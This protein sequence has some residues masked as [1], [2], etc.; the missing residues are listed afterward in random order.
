MSADLLAFKIREAGLPEPERE[1]RFHP[2][3]QWRADFGWPVQGVLVEFEGGAYSGGRHTCGKGFEN[4]CEKYNTAALL[5]YVVLR[6]TARHVESGKAL[7]AIEQAL[8]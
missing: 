5:G 6:F 3:R 7:E 2:E 1:F 8:Q 4:D